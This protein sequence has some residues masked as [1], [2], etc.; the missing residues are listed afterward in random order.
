[1]LFPTIFFNVVSF[2]NA[3]SYDVK[4][5][6]T[7]FLSDIIKVQLVFDKLCLICF[8]FGRLYLTIWGRGEAKA[9]AQK[10]KKVVHFVSV[11]VTFGTSPKVTWKEN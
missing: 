11:H 7:N 9:G 4:Y 6:S 1:M 2:V 5:W 8:H 3:K 10:I